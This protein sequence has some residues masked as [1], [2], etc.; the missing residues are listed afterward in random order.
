MGPILVFQIKWG[1]SI[2]DVTPKR[3]DGVTR[4][5]TDCDK[6]EGESVVL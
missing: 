1:S 5:V 6:G 4:C 3:G 2:N